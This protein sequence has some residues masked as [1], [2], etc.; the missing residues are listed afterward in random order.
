M[1]CRADLLLV[2]TTMGQLWQMQEQ[3]PEAV[4]S[5]S[6]GSELADTVCAMA[7]QGGAPGLLLMAAMGGLAGRERAL[8]GFLY[9]LQELLAGAS[10]AMPASKELQ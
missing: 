6:V 3:T 5:F 10:H 8:V 1:N 9:R 7:R 4:A 2:A